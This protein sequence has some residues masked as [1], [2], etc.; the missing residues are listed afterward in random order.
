MGCEDEFHELDTDIWFKPKFKSVGYLRFDQWGI[1]GPELGRGLCIMCDDNFA[2]NGS[3]LNQCIMDIT[4]GGRAGSQWRG[5]VLGLRMKCV[6]SDS[7]FYTNV[8][9]KEDL[10][11]FVAYFEDYNK[12]M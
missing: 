12:L 3:P 4:S 2:I 11:P 1:D 7:Y 8:N 5:N 10:K 9:M 6:D